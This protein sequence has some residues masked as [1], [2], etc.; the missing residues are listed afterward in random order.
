M[1]FE[2]VPITQ[3]QVRDF[4][5][6]HHRHSAP[7]WGMKFQVGLEHEGRLVGVVCA[8]VPVARN[9]A[10]GR[11]I[12]ITRLCTDGTFNAASALYGAICRAALA[13]GYTRAITYTLQS[14]SG[15]SLRASGWREDERIDRVHDWDRPGRVRPLHRVDLFGARSRR[16]PAKRVRWVRAL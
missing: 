10:D 11:T 6:R 12:E 7:P 16:Y 4:V 9:L 1:G 15:A 13:L 14:E 8:G 3:R 2:L 5:F